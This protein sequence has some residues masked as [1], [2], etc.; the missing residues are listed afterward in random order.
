MCISALNRTHRCLEKISPRN[1]RSIIFV[2]ILSMSRKFDF[3]PEE[4][5]NN[6]MAQ[7]PIQWSSDHSACFPSAK[8]LQLR[9][10]KMNLFVCLVR[11]RSL[12]RCSLC[13]KARTYSLT[14]HGIE[15][16]SCPSDLAQLPLKNVR[17]PIQSLKHHSQICRLR[18]NAT[19]FNHRMS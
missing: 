5:N 2:N 16:N 12:T 13:P 6:V 8:D 1:I 11:M 4:I 10:S 19:I 17:Y 9:Q 7:R 18:E 14:A 3:F 15:R